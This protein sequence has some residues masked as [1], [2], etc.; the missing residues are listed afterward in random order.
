MQPVFS[1]LVGISRGLHVF[2]QHGRVVVSA[3]RVVSLLDSKGGLITEEPA[4][5]A[6]AKVHRIGGGCYLTLGGTTY[7]LR[8]NIFGDPGTFD[9]ILAMRK[10]LKLA[11]QLQALLG[12]EPRPPDP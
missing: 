9:V 10:R 2:A 8:F 6:S 7:Y 11:R 3:D 5:G 12:G 1:E 4:A